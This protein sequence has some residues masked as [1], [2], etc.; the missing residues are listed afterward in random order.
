MPVGPLQIDV[1]LLL[2]DVAGNTGVV[3]EAL[4]EIF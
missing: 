4:T 1:L 3:A 2:P